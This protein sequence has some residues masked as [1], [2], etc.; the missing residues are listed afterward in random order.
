MINSYLLGNTNMACLILGL[1]AAADKLQFVI[2]IQDAISKQENKVVFPFFR[3]VKQ[4]IK[5]YF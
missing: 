5:C 4:V 1:I 3:N 2:N